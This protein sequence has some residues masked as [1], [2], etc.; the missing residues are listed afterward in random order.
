MFQIYFIYAYKINIITYSYII[1]LRNYSYLGDG[2][3][4]VRVT[5]LGNYCLSFNDWEN[6]WDHCRIKLKHDN[7]MTKHYLIEHCLF[8]SL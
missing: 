3:F 1:L 7:S 2:T 4:L 8:D 6:E 5:F